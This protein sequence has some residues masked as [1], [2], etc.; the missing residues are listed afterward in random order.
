MSTIAAGGLGLYT[1]LLPDLALLRR[2]QAT[3]EALAVQ[4][5]KFSHLEIHHGVLVRAHACVI[6]RSY[7]DSR[8]TVLVQACGHFTVSFIPVL[9][10]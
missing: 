3:S 6:P 10:D 8:S 9:G 5:R 7:Q 1:V 4:R 2:I